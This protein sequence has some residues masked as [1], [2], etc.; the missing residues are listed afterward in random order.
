MSTRPPAVAPPP[1]AFSAL[2]AMATEP[3]L[4]LDAAQIELLEAAAATARATAAAHH[5]IRESEELLL[6][7]LGPQ[8]LGLPEARARVA[9]LPGGPQAVSAPKRSFLTR[10]ASGTSCS[11]SV[12]T[13]T[14]LL[15]AENADV[16]IYQDSAQ[17]QTPSRVSDSQ[18]QRV[19]DF[20]TRYGKPVIQSAF[21]APPDRDSNNQI[22]VLVTPEVGG[23]GTGATAAFVWGGDLLP[24]SACQAS[25]EMELVYFNAF[26]FRKMDQGD[27]QAPETLVHEV[28]HI[29]SF[30]QRLNGTVFGIASAWAEE[31]AAEI[32][33]EKASRRAWAATGG[34]AENAMVTAQSFAGNDRFTPENYGVILRLLN[35]TRYLSSQPNSVVYASATGPYTVYGSGW[36]FHRFLGDAYGMAATAPNADAPF[37]LQQTS[38]ATPAGAKGL[39]VLTGKSFAAL[40][41]EYAAAVMLNGTGAPNPTR[42]FTTYNFPSAVGILGTQAPPG[43]YP[44]AVTGTMNNPSV[45]FAAGNWAGVIGNAGLR[46]HDFTSSGMVSAEISVTVEQPARVV[47]ARLR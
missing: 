47:V 33:G 19:L 20:Y 5:R 31:G 7:R 41:V 40:M 16:A 27:F 24:R 18:A 29:V 22:V 35:S 3:T 45:A 34:P 12:Q 37:F 1:I 23:E 4:Q 10:S 14:G 13:A 11:A 17:A 39:P 38:S 43:R 32:A 44:Y 15:I 9:T 26:M 28:K 8:P 36:H 21:G 2:Q 25:N 42:G 6:R 46:I 30:Q